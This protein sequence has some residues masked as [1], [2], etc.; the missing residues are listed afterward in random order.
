MPPGADRCEFVWRETTA[1]DWTH[2]IDMATAK[3]AVA[4]G[5]RWRACLPGVCL[6]DAIVGVRSV[7]Q[8]G[9]RSRV[10]TPPEPD[11]LDQRAGATPARTGGEERGR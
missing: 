6:D 3:P 8:D 10:A 1:A 9:S 11:R 2:T 7:G 5:S 4:R